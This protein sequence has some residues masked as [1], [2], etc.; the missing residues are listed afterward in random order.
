MLPGHI[1]AGLLGSLARSDTGG[2]YASPLLTCASNDRDQLDELISPCFR[3]FSPLAWSSSGERCAQQGRR[4]W[5][6][7]F[8]S[9]FSGAPLFYRTYI[10]HSAFQSP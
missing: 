3:T 5:I 1:Q 9:S 6:S 7:K 2:G 8:V 10:L 4:R